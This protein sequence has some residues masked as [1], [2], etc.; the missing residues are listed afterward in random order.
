[1]DALLL[2]NT[3]IKEHQPR[4]NINLKDDKSYPVIRITNEAFPKVFAMR[5]PVRDGSEYFGP[6]ASLKMMQTVLELT[7]KLYPTRNC[8]LNMT[9][10]SI[11]A[12]KFKICLEYQIGNC[13]G[14]CQAYQSQEEY[15]ES[16]AN[17]RHILKGNLGEVKRHLKT[18]MEEAVKI[19]NFEKAQEIKE[20]LESLQSYQSKSTV[21]NTK[22]DNTDVF[23]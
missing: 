13:M 6:Y 21:V 9:P 12:G 23:G 10:E 3:L 4:Y 16:I 7:R 1:F 20:K 17:I 15:L 11:A 14:P 18:E 2:E 22:I 8:N 5:N 19:L